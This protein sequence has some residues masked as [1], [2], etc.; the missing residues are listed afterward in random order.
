[1]AVLEE[2][3]IVGSSFEEDTSDGDDL[4]DRNDQDQWWI[5]Q[6]DQKLD[7]RILLVV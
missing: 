6:N 5:Y 2:S 3:T 1:M 7:C 4:D